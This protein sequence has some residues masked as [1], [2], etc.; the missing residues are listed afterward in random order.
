[1]QIIQCQVYR[2]VILQLFVWRKLIAY[3]T[4][5]PLLIDTLEFYLVDINHLKVSDQHLQK[6]RN[7]MSMIMV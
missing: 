4:N 7:F 1:M 3:K 5:Y 2:E 6:Q